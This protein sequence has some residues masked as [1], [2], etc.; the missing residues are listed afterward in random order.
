MYFSLHGSFSSPKQKKGGLTVIFDVSNR[1]RT[2]SIFLALI[3]AHAVN[4]HMDYVLTDFHAIAANHLHASSSIASKRKL[5]GYTLWRFT[6]SLSGTFSRK[7]RCRTARPP[8][9]PA[10]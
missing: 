7:R 5:T 10:E 2:L 9:L 6:P 8:A 4:P 1:P 3:T